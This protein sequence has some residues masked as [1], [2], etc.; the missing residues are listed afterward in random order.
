MALD[1]QSIIE[2]LKGASILELND[3]VKAIEDEFN[4]S[5]AAPVAA[6]GAAGGADAGAE[7]T[8][9]DVELTESGQEKVKVIKAVREITGQGL[10]DAKGM[11]DSAPT[12]IKEKV[13]KDEADKLKAQ[14]E[15]VG[16]TV[17]IK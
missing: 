2:Q 3:L 10:K 11:V 17:T 15:E 4:V 13:S 12:V 7:Q 8:E 1:T 5:A 14:L 9:F 6:A 16:A